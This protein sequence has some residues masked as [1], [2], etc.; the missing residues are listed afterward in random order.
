[1]TPSSYV[2][3]YKE[4]RI[5]ANELAR[6]IVS[7]DTGRIGIVRRAREKK[8]A[9]AVRYSDV[10]TAIAAAMCDPIKGAAIAANAYES[11]EQKAS[12]TALSPW[13]RED[14]AKSLD[15]LDAYGLMK[16]SLAGFDFVPAP[17]QQPMLKLGGVIVSVSCDVVIHRPI[18]AD[19]CIGA[20]LFRLTKP[21]EDET[22]KAK[23]KRTAM[24]KLVATLVM[25]QVSAN[26]SGNRKPHHD[27]CWSIDM[28]TGEIHI[29]PKNSK[30]LIANIENACLSISGL[31]DRV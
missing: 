20:A 9:I 23:S 3:Y 15:V 12:D 28:Q 11:F 21:D 27:L 8:S 5:S 29:A 2:Q 4:P 25:M 19:E 7:G 1:M 18:K 31:W 17:S 26:L 10:R 14:A 22:E 13:S 6:F 24:G 16:N 30:A